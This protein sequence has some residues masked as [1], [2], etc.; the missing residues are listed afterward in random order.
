MMENERVLRT[1]ALAALMLTVTLG[2]MAS[3]ARPLRRPADV[4]L[5][6]WQ[7]PEDLRFADG[8][9]CAYLVSTARVSAGRLLVEG[10]R[11][12]LQVSAQSRRI[13][14]LR[15]EVSAGTRPEDL[16]AHRAALVQLVENMGHGADWVQI[17]FDARRSE[18]GFYRDL[19]N[20][21]RRALPPST[22]ISI[23]ALAS[24]CGDDPWLAGLPVDEAVPMLFRLGRDAALIR[25]QLA[26]GRDFREPLC[27]GA[28]GL[29][30]DEP[31]VALRPGRRVYLFHP[32]AWLP[33]DF[34]AA[35]GR[36]EESLT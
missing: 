13:P 20:D 14:V 25:A 27:R 21:L 16:A 7:R 4:V 32:R 8:A 5:W 34:D 17:D 3:S 33:S 2:S 9:A 31:F 15:I 28:Y 23:T 26:R 10:R 11:Q 30:T 6:A 29:S 18:R 35:L 22:H 36:L 19:L 1:R 12:P 24:W